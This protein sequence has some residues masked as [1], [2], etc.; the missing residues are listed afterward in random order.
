MD[1]L[2]LPPLVETQSNSKP[3]RTQQR[4]MNC[5]QT[6]LKWQKSNRIT[7]F[8]E[9]V[10]LNYFNEASKT[11][12]SS[13]LMSMYSMLKDTLNRHHN[14]DISTNCRLLT[15]LREKFEGFESKKFKV[16]T[17]EEINKFLVEAPDEHYL[18]MKVCC[19]ILKAIEIVDFL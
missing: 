9:D 5:Y 14:I 13:T 7:A 15:F 16:F 19:I 10:L 8:D 12:K 17:A 4:Y 11:Y 6:F 1:D 2:D 18:A 3:E